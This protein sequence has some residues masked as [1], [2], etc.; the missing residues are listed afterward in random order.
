[1]DEGALASIHSLTR[2][3]DSWLHLL[4]KLCPLI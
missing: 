3:Y 4:H 1:M 2:Y